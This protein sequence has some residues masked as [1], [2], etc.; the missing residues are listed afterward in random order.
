MWMLSEKRL[1]TRWDRTRP[2][3]NEPN[4]N[5]KFRVASVVGML[6]VS[7]WWDVTL[8]PCALC[9]LV[10]HI[11]GHCFNIYHISSQTSNDLA[12]LFRNYFHAYVSLTHNII[13]YT[14]LIYCIARWYVASFFLYVAR[15]QDHL[16]TVHNDLPGKH[17]SLGNHNFVSIDLTGA[18]SA[19]LY[20]S[21]NTFFKKGTQ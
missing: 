2:S 1:W 15:G 8:L 17:F 3:R 13:Q 11:V 7:S 6:V 14:I 12:C 18:D 20:C 4:P 19:R 21:I 9:V 5:P 10:V 16:P